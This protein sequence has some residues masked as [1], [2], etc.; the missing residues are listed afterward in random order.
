MVAAVIPYARR[1]ATHSRECI[2]MYSYARD[3]E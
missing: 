2:A 3:S 1:Y